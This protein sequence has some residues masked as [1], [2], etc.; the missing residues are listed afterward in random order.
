MREGPGIGASPSECVG[1]L[2]RSRPIRPTVVVLLVLGAVACNRRPIAAGTRDGGRP[3]DS[4][5]PTADSGARAAD[6]GAE[7][8]DGSTSCADVACGPPP[9]DG[10]DDS[11]WAPPALCAL[12]FEVGPCDAVV[13]VF[14]SSTALACGG[15]TEVA[16]ATPTVLRRSK[17]AWRR[18]KVDLGRTRVQRTASLSGSVWSADRPAVAR[19]CSMS[20]RSAASRQCFVVWTGWSVSEASVS[21]GPAIETVLARRRETLEKR[22]VREAFVENALQ[23]FPILAVDG[24][25]TAQRERS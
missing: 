4:G 9:G 5:S 20:A 12:A 18:A 15:R 22:A 16:G 25:P 24:R 2:R 6:S 3:V 17:S 19:C 10:G 13:G 11:G 23:T 1:F 7:V 8:S 14:A 21:P